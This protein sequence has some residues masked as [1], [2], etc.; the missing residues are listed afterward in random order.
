MA[1]EDQAHGWLL[2]KAEA[3]GRPTAEKAAPQRSAY[4]TTADRSNALTIVNHHDMRDGAKR[5]SFLA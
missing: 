2:A 1:D 4:E 5:L 3:N